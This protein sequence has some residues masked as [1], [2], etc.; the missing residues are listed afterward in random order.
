VRRRIDVD[1]I[2]TFVETL[3]LLAIAGGG[4]AVVAFLF[5]RF[6]WFQ[7]LSGDAKWWTILGLSLGI[8]LLAQIVLTVVPAETFTLLEPFWIALAT[9]FVSWLASQVTHLWYLRQ[10]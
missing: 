2:P 6:K 7:K 3:K 5:E 4:G 1:N 9:G 8:P 10:K